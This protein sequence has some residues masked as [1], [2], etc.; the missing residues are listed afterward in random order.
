MSM[1]NHTHSGSWL[2]PHQ[3]QATAA[4]TSSRDAGRAQQTLVIA[5]CLAVAVAVAVI[6]LVPGTP[7]AVAHNPGAHGRVHILAELRPTPAPEPFPAAASATTV[8][9]VVTP[10]A[11]N[12]ASPPA[13]RGQGRGAFGAARLLRRI[14]KGTAG[15][16]ASGAPSGGATAS[17]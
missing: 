5:L 12:V 9:A 14:G 6:L 8:G 3:T 13:S 11:T 2:G 15:A 1:L 16:S 17:L 10:V 4:K 7:R